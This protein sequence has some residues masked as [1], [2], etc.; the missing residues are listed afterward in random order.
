MG[1]ARKPPEEEGAPAYMAQYTA[2]M[3]I[4]LAFF[5]CM[6]TMGEEKASEF[7]SRGMGYIKDAFGLK[8]GLG[9]LNYWKA[10]MRKFPETRYDEEKDKDR[11]LL[12]YQKGAFQAE[13]LDAEGILKMEMQDWGYS[14]RIK[15]PLTIGEKSV[16]LDKEAR[17][18]L[19]K[20]GGVFYNLPGYVITAC[21]YE[22]RNED[23]EENLRK[24]SKS[25]ATVTAYLE[26][27]CG[28]P[29]ERL[30]S[31]GYSSSRYLGDNGNSNP[32]QGVVFFIRKE[33]SRNHL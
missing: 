26:G 22:S 15:T 2:L 11:H 4:L 7:Q 1:K 3:T 25:A 21:C 13:Q 14:V 31:I 27:K 32:D 17:S 33:A 23:N 20:V 5:I 24:A 9:L 19:D 28:I 8:G 10:I 18:F 16:V 29:R 12:G 30:N 6:L